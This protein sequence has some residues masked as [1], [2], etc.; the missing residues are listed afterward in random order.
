MEKFIKNSLVLGLL[1]CPGLFFFNPPFWVQL[2]MREPPLDPFVKDIAGHAGDCLNVCSGNSQQ[3]KLPD[4]RGQAMSA[5]NNNEP[6]ID[7]QYT[8]AV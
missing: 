2:P 7:E 8:V 6:A 4:F 5:A 3:D 1:S